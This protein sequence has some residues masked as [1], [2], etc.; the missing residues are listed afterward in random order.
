M[1]N[2]KLQTWAL[3]AEIIG[4]TAVVLSLIFVGYQIRQSSE[5]TELN[6]RSVAVSAYQDL[7][8]QIMEINFNN[9]N[10]P[11]L[12]KALGNVRSGIELTEDQEGLFTLNVIN[13][14]RHGDMAYYQYEQGLIDESRLKSALG[15]LV[16]NLARQEEMRR[17]WDLPNSYS[18][19]YKEYVNSLLRE[20]QKDQS[21]SQ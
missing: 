1:N 18:D 6:T 4:G 10:N 15:I 14:F 9:M 12:R 3:I 19:A 2:E 17:R 20:R 8:N 11:E 21:S 7:M 13:I 16:T 5:E